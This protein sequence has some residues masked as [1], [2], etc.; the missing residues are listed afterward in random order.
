MVGVADCSGAKVIDGDTNVVAD[1][2]VRLHGID[3]PELDRTFRWRGQQIACGTMSLAA[4]EALIVEVKVRCEVVERNRHGHLGC[5]LPA[6]S[7]EK[8]PGRRNEALNCRV[9]APAAIYGLDRFEERHWRRME[10][11]LARIPDDQRDG[12]PPGQHSVPVRPLVRHVIHSGYM[13]R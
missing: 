13:A 12:E 9:Y 4:L 10:E 6:A 11:A 7:L 2:L 5:K 3:A 1:Q 8:E